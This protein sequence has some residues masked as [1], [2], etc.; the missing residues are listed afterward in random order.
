MTDSV[1]R[2]SNRVSNYVKYRPQYP[3]EI[4]T[5]LK[6][7]FGLAPGSVV[8]DVGCGTGISSKIFL[9][10]G[11]R[12]FGVE[13]ND[14]MRAAAVEY[15]REFEKFAPVKGTSTVTTLENSSVDL[16]VAAQAFHWFDPEPTRNEFRRILKP[17]G[18]VVLIWNE[19]QLDTTAFH[20]EYEALLVKYANDYGHVR[21]ENIAEEELRAFFQQPYEQALFPNEQVFDFDGLK[22]RM[23]SASYMPTENDPRFRSLANELHAIFAKHAENGRIRVLYDTRVYTS[24]F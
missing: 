2:F 23:L 16:I 24:Q 6:D 9:E 5:Y 17:G 19:R 11:N 8:A 15:L 3:R 18:Y 12:V 20:R 13:P 7:S 10:N 22:G 1:E 4:V 21:H 14:A